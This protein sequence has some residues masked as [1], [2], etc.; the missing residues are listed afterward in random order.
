MVILVA[1]TVIVTL[2]GTTYGSLANDYQNNVQL[3]DLGKTYMLYWSLNASEGMMYF[4]VQVKT[5]GWVGFGFAN[6]IGNMDNYDVM[7]AYV[8]T[9][10][11]TTQ[12]NVSSLLNY[13]LF[14][15]P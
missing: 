3:D 2:I 5:T 9:T 10:T 11:K 4:A 13:I 15:S 6:K 1:F 12:I 8:I 7:I 14:G